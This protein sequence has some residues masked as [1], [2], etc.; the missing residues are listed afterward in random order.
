[1]S[2][3]TQQVIDAANRIA[4]AIGKRDVAALGRELAP[5]FL[6]RAPGE[7]ERSQEAFLDAI[8]QIPG[9]IVF[10]KLVALTVDVFGEGAVATGVQHAQVRVEDQT[11][12]DQRPFVDWFVKHDGEWRLRLAVDLPAAS[13]QAPDAGA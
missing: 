6:M 4:E 9:E 2:S 10:V 11:I 1:M 5:G 7:I 8:E 12:D 13:G 3:D